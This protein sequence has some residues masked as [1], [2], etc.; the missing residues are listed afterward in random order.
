MTNRNV[1][2]EKRTENAGNKE[3]NKN[4]RQGADRTKEV[5]QKEK[6]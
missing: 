3:R 2:L 5:P 6:I 1:S 4:E